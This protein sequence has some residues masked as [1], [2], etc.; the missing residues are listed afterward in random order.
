MSVDFTLT[1]TTMFVAGAFFGALL[2]RTI[3][4][5]IMALWLVLKLILSF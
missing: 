2:G 3:T 4:F 1:L 5:F